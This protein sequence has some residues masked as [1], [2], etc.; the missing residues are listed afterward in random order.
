VNTSS[1]IPCIPESAPFSPEQRIWLNGFLAGLFSRMPLASA[2][3]ATL[4]PLA[5]LFGS[6][7]GTAESL[8][9]QAAKQA[10]S[11]GFAPTVLDMAQV[12]LATLAQHENLLVIT[13]T[14]GDGEPPDNARALVE[15][16]GGPA[17]GSVPGLRF[18]V[19]GLGDTNYAQFCQC[20]KQVDLSLE[21]R[22]GLRVSP[23][24]DCDTDFEGPFKGWLTAALSALS[25]QA[26]AAA[27]SHQPLSGA[28]PSRRGY[29]RKEPVMAPLLASR[30]LSLEGSAKQVNHVEFSLKEVGLTYEPGD[31]LGV[32]PQNRGEL[33]DE[34]LSLLRCDGEEAVPL[35]NGEQGAL[36]QALAEHYDLCRPSPELVSRFSA[37]SGGVATATLHVVD[38]LATRPETRLS[39]LE[40]VALLKPIAP[41]LYSISSSPLA[42]AGS[43]HLTVGAVHYEAL[44]RIRHGVCST[45]LAEGCRTGASVPI[46]VHA[47]PAFR[48]TA[49]H[50]APLIMI[51][52]GTGIAPFRGFLHH[53]EASGAKGRNWLF[54]GDQR[55]ATDFLYQEELA[56]FQ[57]RGLLSRLDTAF[58]RDQAEKIYVQH[59]M[60]AA[61]RDLY[62]WL[63]EGGM[64][65]VCGDASRMAKDVDQALHR[66]VQEA[67]GRSAAQAADYVQ[68]LRASKRYLRDVY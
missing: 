25:G 14:Y 6:Q 41:R 54:F 1:Q 2:P 65:Y 23:R 60:L 64:V 59:R 36:R 45:Y 10:A 8:A 31:A 21:R 5:I 53:R 49:T 46:F 66:V 42:H 4:K 12:S 30:T 44:G 34:F 58:S 17:Q 61:S 7:T 3:A 16:L 56:G 47:N 24:V 32:F 26:A 55:S 15:A 48:L 38:I 40:L 13:S 9:K 51:G 68:A 63:E 39:P 62:A 22:G 52:P 11:H 37:E 27:I 29:S 35:P 19:C 18:S 33:V 67:S 43:V 57:A 28:S 50:D 20:A